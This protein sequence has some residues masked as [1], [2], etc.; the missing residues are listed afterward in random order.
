ME[1]AEYPLK[2]IVVSMPGLLGLRFYLQD[3]HG[4]ICNTEDKNIE[5]HGLKRFT[6]DLKPPV[7]LRTSSLDGIGTLEVSVLIQFERKIEE[8][9]ELSELSSN[10]AIVLVFGR[11]WSRRCI[12]CSK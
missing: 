9:Q 7:H 11:I 3:L 6:V 8:V 5:T 1:M 12:S 4:K 2:W 10:A